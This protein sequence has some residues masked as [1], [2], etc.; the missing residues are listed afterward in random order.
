V[1]I[2]LAKRLGV[3]GAAVV[4]PA[5]LKDYL[6]N[7]ARSFIYTTALPPHSLLAIQAAHHYVQQYSEAQETLHQ[8]IAIF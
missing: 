1:C 3:H 4:G 2:P 6:V 7:F 5:A 8:R